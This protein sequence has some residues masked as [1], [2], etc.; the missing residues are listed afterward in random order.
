MTSGNT[1]PAVGERRARW[2]TGPGP[3]L[4]PHH[5]LVDGVR[6]VRAGD[7]GR[8]GRIGDIPGGRGTAVPDRAGL[9]YYHAG[10][11][12][13]PYLGVLTHTED[14]TPTLAAVV[15]ENPAGVEEACSSP[16]QAPLLGPKVRIGEG[17]GEAAGGGVRTCT[18]PL[19]YPFRNW[20]DGLIPS[21]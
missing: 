3:A 15:P 8:R 1:E 18:W 11:P 2:P 21:P 13:R 14:V 4:V 20:S 17:G 5:C 9:F 12:L 7:E 10:G 6:P 19:T 16:S